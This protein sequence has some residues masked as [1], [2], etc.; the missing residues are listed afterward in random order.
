MP[1]SS[2]AAANAECESRQNAHSLS[3]DTCAA[4]SSRSP[5][6]NEFGARSNASASACSGPPVSGR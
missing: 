5:R 2:C 3:A 1:G 4:I 6:D